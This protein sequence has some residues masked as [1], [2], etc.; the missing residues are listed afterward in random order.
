MVKTKQVTR[1]K[2]KKRTFVVADPERD[3]V[4]LDAIY[5]IKLS[6]YLWCQFFEVL[7]FLGG[8]VINLAMFV[9]LLTL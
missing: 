9:G 6:L 5:L 4:L 7:F 3:N 1:K 8:G 2:K